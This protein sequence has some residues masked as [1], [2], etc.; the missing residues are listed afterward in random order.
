MELQSIFFHWVIVQVTARASRCLIDTYRC[1][2]MAHKLLD[3]SACNCDNAT[4]LHTNCTE[5]PATI[6]L[7]DPE[8]RMCAVQCGLMIVFGKLPCGACKAALIIGPPCVPGL[9]KKLFKNY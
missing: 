8:L 5:L 9:H 4:R 3:M 6:G 7:L 1:C 2:A